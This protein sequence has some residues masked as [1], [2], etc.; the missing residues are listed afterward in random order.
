MTNRK[1]IA[2]RWHK[3]ADKYEILAWQF[4]DLAQAADAT[5]A[6]RAIRQQASANCLREAAYCRRRALEFDERNKANEN[7]TNQTRI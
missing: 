4:H 1:R 3:K 2:D 6:E 7:N 5:P